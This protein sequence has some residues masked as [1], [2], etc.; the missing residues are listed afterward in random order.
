MEY[1]KDVVGF[2][3]YQVSN[4]G[5]VKTKSRM[6]RYTHSVTKKEH[7]RKSE[8][9]FLKIQFN[10]RTGYKF[11]QLYKEK[12]MYNKNIHKLVSEAFISNPNDLKYVNHKDG[13]KHNNTIENLEFCTNEY[14][15]EHAIKT[16]LKAKG[17][18]VASSKL[19]ENMVYAIKWFLNKG[20]SHMEL[21]KAFNVSR[22]TIN[23][24]SNN[25]TWKHVELTGEELILQGKL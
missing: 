3:D 6:I 8:E 11:V 13:N 9:R 14:N 24:I 22:P 16:G 1:F 19:N 18:G 23:L 2:P 4:L 7:F 15:H 17:S 20:Y 10:N 5:R 25:K 12:K 21:S